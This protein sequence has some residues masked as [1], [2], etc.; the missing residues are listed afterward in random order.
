MIS[1]ASGLSYEATARDMSETNYSSARQSG[2]EDDL[3]YDEEKELL[4]QVLD[5]IYE[6][7]VI[8]CWLKGI[9]SGNDFWNNIRDYTAHEWVVK[10]KRSMNPAKEANANATMLKT[11][12]KTFQ[13]IY[14]KPGGTGNRSLTRWMRQ[15]GTLLKRTLT[16]LPCWREGQALRSQKKRRE[17]RMERKP[18]HK[19]PGGE[20][21]FCPTRFMNANI[22]ASGESGNERQFELSF[23]SEEPY[24]RWYGVEI[25][26][27]SGGYMDLTTSEYRSRF[28]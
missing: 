18:M 12:Q 28:V 6:T 17:R 27:H 15:T 25:L 11:G 1:S 3:T 14:A 2:I 13:Q 19:N 7:F 10:P 23:S 9:I 26:N 20:N 4:F 22:R 8:S 5:E 16:W 24:S 21:D